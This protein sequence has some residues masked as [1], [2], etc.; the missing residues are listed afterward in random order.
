[1]AI[2]IYIGLV[3][4]LGII[5][6]IPILGVII[7]IFVGFYVAVVMSYLFGSVFRG[8]TAVAPPVAPPM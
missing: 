3:I 8:N 4:V 1:M 6:M 2:L 5:K 7:D